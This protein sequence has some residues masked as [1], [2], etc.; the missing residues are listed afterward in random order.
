MH[1]YRVEANWYRHWAQLCH[2]ICPLPDFI[3]DYEDKTTGQ[4]ILVLSDLDAQGYNQ[5]RSQLTIDECK[6]VIT[7][8]ARFHSQFMTKEP[9]ENWCEGLWPIGS[10]WHLSTRPDEF[11]AMPP[12]SLKQHAAQ[13]D[14]Q[15]NQSQFTT[16][17]HGDAKVANFCFAQDFAQ[18]F[19]DY[20][21]NNGVAAV[22]FQY[23]GAGVGVKDLVYFL[24]SCLT[25]NECEQD[26]DSLV[27]Y[28]FEQ[29]G[30]CTAGK[31]TTEDRQALD[32]E[33]RQLLIFA[34]ADFERFLLGWAPEHHKR[35][36]FSQAM[37]HQALN[38]LND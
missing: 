35:N 15:L 27:D 34:W 6:A 1:S 8:L 14:S 25:P 7:W 32:N 11:A 17:I 38:L 28:Y 13:I 23:V 31:F 2:D 10:Y 22:D 4:S 26:Y 29:L 12:G 30:Q 21:V 9:A 20:P 5:R 18:H 36:R 33:W 3:A 16:L 37:T 19:A 24:G